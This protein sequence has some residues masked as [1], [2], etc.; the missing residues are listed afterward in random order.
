MPSNQKLADPRTTTREA[1]RAIAAS[2]PASYYIT[3]GL[4]STELGP[5]E[6]VSSETFITLQQAH[7]RMLAAYRQQNWRE[8]RALADACTELDD[9]LS[10]LYDHYRDRIGRFELE[11]P[12]ENWDGGLAALTK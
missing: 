8:A 11:P 3:A 6:M 12:G 4:H 10:V 7:D 9:T 5:P 2:I 1:A